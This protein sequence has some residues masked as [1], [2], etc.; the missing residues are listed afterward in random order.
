MIVQREI[1]HDGDCLVLFH[2][3]GRNMEGSLVLW[4]QGDCQSAEGSQGH[5]A[6]T[7]GGYQP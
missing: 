7:L 4:E 3:Q 5:R 6:A 1:Y 2:R